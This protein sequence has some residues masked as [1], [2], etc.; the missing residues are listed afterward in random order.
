M[1]KELRNEAMRDVPK[2]IGGRYERS[3]REALDKAGETAR[4]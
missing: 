2:K 4:K 3:W 1:L